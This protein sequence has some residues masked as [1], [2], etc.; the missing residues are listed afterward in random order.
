MSYHHGNCTQIPTPGQKITDSVSYCLVKHGTTV[1]VVL[2]DTTYTKTRHTLFLFGHMPVQ[3]S[4][5]YTDSYRCNKHWKIKE[6]SKKFFMYIIVP[7]ATTWNR[8]TLAYLTILVPNT[9]WWIIYWY[10]YTSPTCCII[11]VVIV[12]Y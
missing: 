8:K 11:V 9:V 3:H 5:G 6:I 4:K 1:R 12:I 10:P 7:S 2:V